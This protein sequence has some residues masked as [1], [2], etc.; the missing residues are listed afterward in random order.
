M[1]EFIPSATVKYQ[2]KREYD[3]ECRPISLRLIKHTINGN[4]YLYATTLI[5]QEYKTSLFADLY[6]NKWI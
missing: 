3:I 5:C 4:V 2:I 6:D 1:V